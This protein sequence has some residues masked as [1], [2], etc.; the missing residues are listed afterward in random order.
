M[1]QISLSQI[2]HSWSCLWLKP[3]S[4]SKFPHW[5]RLFVTLLYTP[6]YLKGQETTLHS[7]PLNTQTHKKAKLYFNKNQFYFPTHNVVCQSI[8]EHLPAQARC[9]HFSCYFSSLPHIPE[10]QS[11]VLWLGCLQFREVFGYQCSFLTQQFSPKL[12]IFK[13]EEV[14]ESK[15]PSQN[16]EEL[17]RLRPWGIFP[18]NHWLDTKSLPSALPISDK[19]TYWVA[20]SISWYYSYI[21][22]G[23]ENP[24]NRRYSK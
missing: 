11:F 16:E 9:S 20:A 10:L 19:Y 22:K 4:F 21:R 2:N 8:H 24:W 15:L 23:E 3:L 1:S 13:Q 17:P 18:Q 7:T 6:S 12:K 5:V 14:H